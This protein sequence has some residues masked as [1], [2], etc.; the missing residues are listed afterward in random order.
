MCDEAAGAL[1]LQNTVEDQLM[2][3]GE[4]KKPVVVF[5][6]DQVLGDGD[7]RYS[8]GGAS[9]TDSGRGNSDCG[10]E[11]STPSMSSASAKTSPR[12]D[13]IHSKL[14]TPPLFGTIRLRFDG[15]PTAVR[16]RIKGH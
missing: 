9:L 7:C 3:G 11:Q 5:V 10:E 6:R 15:R 12:H 8:P 1:M 4:V 14:I 13:A 16:L 2:A